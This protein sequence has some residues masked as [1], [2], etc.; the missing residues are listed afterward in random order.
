LFSEETRV[1]PILLTLLLVLFM[2]L[3]VSI[4]YATYYYILILRGDIELKDVANMQ[5][6]ERWERIDGNEEQK[7]DV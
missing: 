4:T 7:N 5:Y 2:F 6:Y 1:G 3:G